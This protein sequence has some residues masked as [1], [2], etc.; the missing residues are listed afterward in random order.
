MVSWYHGSGVRRGSDGSS[1]GSADSEQRRHHPSRQH[2]LRDCGIPRSGIPAVCSIQRHVLRAG[3]RGNQGSQEIQRPTLI[4][5]P[6]QG[7]I[8]RLELANRVFHRVFDNRLIFPPVASPRNI[9]DLGCG[10]GDWAVQVSEQ[11]PD[12][13]VSGTRSYTPV[14]V[15]SVVEV[16]SL[17]EPMLWFRVFQRRLSRGWCSPTAQSKD[18]V[19]SACTPWDAERAFPGG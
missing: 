2:N 19:W 17:A 14:H 9:L 15:A 10:G 12:A 18:L 7:E 16:L 13:S 1:G 6:I 3:R 11:Y 5:S 4:S 8:A